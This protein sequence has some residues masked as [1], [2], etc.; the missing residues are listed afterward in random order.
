MFH[1]YLIIN[2]ESFIVLS[3]GMKW[4]RARIEKI[5]DNQTSDS[6][7]SFCEKLNNL[8]LTDAELVLIFLLVFTSFSK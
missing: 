1:S 7:F 3:D 5:S 8:K 4:S 6:M 2:G